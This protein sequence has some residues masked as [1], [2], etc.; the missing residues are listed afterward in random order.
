[1]AAISV[2]ENRSFNFEDSAETFHDCIVKT[3]QP[4][5]GFFCT[6]LGALQ[7][8]LQ[9]AHFRRRQFGL[10][11]VILAEFFGLTFR[12]AGLFLR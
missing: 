12:R 1:M 11:A 3:Q 6:T 2:R 9:R 4:L 8:L 7:P 5:L 10:F